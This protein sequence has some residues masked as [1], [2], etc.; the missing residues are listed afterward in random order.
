V[1]VRALAALALCLG[2]CLLA[3]PS[4]ARDP[5]A[6]KQAKGAAHAVDPAQARYIEELVQRARALR[7]AEHVTW[8]RLVHYRRSLFG[9]RSEADAKSFFL[10][11][12]GKGSPEAE[13][14]A[15]LRGL[16]GAAPKD[17]RWEHPFCRFPARLAWLNQKLGFDF[18]RVP[19]RVCPRFQDYYDK[20][21]PRSLVLVFSSYYLNNPASAFGHTFLRVNKQRDGSD[22]EGIELLDYGVDYSATVDTGNALIYA[23]KGLTGLF[24]GVFRK[25]PYYLKV[26]EYNDYDSRDLWEYELALT[27]GELS[28][29][30]AHLWELGS[31]Y[32]DYFYLSENCSYHILAALEV[33]NPRF[34]LLERV[35]WP[36]IPADTVKA[37]EAERGLVRKVHYRP[38]IRSQFRVRLEQLSAEERDAVAEL[39]SDPD[40][41]LPRAF[42]ERTRARV[43]DAALDLADFRYSRDLVREPGKEASPEGAIIKQRLLERRAEVAIDSEDL[44][45]AAPVRKMPHL[46]HDSSRLGLGSG[47][48]EDR[49]AFHT[50]DFRV[51]LHDLADSAA[52]Y[53]DT[54]AVEFLP[55]R[56]RY[57][58]EDPALSLE[59]VSLIR[60][61]SL[62]PL[63]RFEKNFSWTLRAGATRLRD[64]GCDGCFTG[65][66][67]FGGGYTLGSPT[68]LLV[69]ALANARVHWPVDDGGLLDTIRAGIGPA[70]GMRLRIGEDFALLGTASWHWLPGQEP[71]SMW[72]AHGIA[73][74]EYVRDFALSFEASAQPNALAAQAFSLI[75]F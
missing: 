52:G 59:D 37:V 4:S 27:P 71:L 20:L 54:A 8:L 53:P 64:A 15:T 75:Y 70:G 10:S 55:V 40:T 66:G 72:E 51:A 16:F 19:R 22:D 13:L 73:R 17:K 34:R 38:S 23:I 25:V 12:E 6:S 68:G 28:M 62:T 74:W 24:P 7:L 49:G 3:Q 65:A 36:V 61:T 41:T 5:Q 69:W 47:Y 39:A 35:G 18:A 57:Y 9:W 43:L 29:V 42:T 31:T 32:F 45:A 58:V 50:L 67:E 60:V 11:P 1:N 26:R 33:A 30:V 63:N 14:E 21:R 44:R 48:L 56:L 46:G 2:S